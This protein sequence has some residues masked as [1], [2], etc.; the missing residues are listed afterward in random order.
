MIRS[1]KEHNPKAIQLIAW[2]HDTNSLETWLPTT[3]FGLA[4]TLHVISV[5]CYCGHTAQEVIFRSVQIKNN[6]SININITTNTVK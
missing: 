6:K 5:E 3:K 1:E 2:P 4:T